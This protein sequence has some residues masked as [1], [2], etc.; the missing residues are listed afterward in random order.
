[1]KIDFI[2]AFKKTPR[3][4][5]RSFGRG[6]ELNAVVSFSFTTKPYSFAVEEKPRTKVRGECHSSRY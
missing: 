4:Q 3:Q 5:L 2:T 1:M 6:D